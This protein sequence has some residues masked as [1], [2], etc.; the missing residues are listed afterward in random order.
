M[1]SCARIE[2]SKHQRKVSSS[3][4]RDMKRTDDWFPIR[5]I[6]NADRVTAVRTPWSFF[7]LKFF[8]NV[9]NSLQDCVARD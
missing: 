8:F 7:F 5:F 3:C 4:E 2:S 9:G 1:A 6:Y